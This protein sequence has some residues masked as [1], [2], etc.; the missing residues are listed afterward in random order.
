[1]VDWGMNKGRTEV[2]RQWEEWRVNEELAGIERGVYEGRM[3]G[4]QWVN[5]G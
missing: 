1:M 5:R 4:D 3:G 2:D